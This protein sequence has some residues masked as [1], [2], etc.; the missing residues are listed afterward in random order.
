M[1]CWMYK[2]R[3]LEESPDGYYGF[4]YVITDDQGRKYYGK[5]AFSHKRKRRL[6]KKARQGRLTRIEIKEVD[7]NWINYW[8]SCKPLLEYIKQRGSTQ[9]F[10]REV[11]KLCH[12]KQSLT[13]WEMATMVDQEVLFRDDCWNGNI[14]SKF[15]KGKITK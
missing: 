8:G 13:Y 1:S 14:L 5:K 10:T 7:S 15:F 2:K 12:D 3:C 11:I 9:G 4:I 6:S